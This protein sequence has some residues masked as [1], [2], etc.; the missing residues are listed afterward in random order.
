MK[1]DFLSDL[2]MLN[3]QYE[4]QEK[5]VILAE[6]IVNS[7]DY[8]FSKKHGIER[9]GDSGDLLLSFS[10]KNRSE[11][12]IIKHYY[13]DCACNEFMYCK[14][15]ELL[16]IKFPKVRLFILDENEKRKYFKTEY[17]IGIEYLN[18]ISEGVNFD[19][20][21]Q[22]EILNDTDFFKFRTLYSLFSESDSFEVVHASDN[23]IYKIDNTDSFSISE[24]LTASMGVIE[25]IGKYGKITNDED[26]FLIETFLER[27]LS[28]K[29]ITESYR[30]FI[31][32]RVD[33]MAQSV[34]C[35]NF[36]YG[37]NHVKEKYGKEYIQYYLQ[38]LK[39]IQEI[40]N[41][42]IN[43]IINTLCI[44]YPDFIGEYYKKYIEIAKKK[45]KLFLESLS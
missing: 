11:R 1:R 19:Y 28:E 45:A 22:H 13:T 41:D 30:T 23:Y 39:D 33:H 15:G 27:T 26:R 10:K 34:H 3:K 36:E 42:D 12:Y 40:S 37:F 25:L 5:A 6:E 29:D 9:L 4:N 8:I 2:R 21:E 20:I 18:I 17:I 7:K 14:I 38:P 43:N 32:E 16:D 24:Q 31:L 35:I 44:I